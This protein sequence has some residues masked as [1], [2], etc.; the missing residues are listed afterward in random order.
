MDL[1]KENCS[2]EFLLPPLG[3]SRSLLSKHGFIAAYM[4]DKNHEPHYQEAVYLLFKPTSITKFEY[5]LD[6]EYDRIKNI[7]EIVEDYDYPGGYV[8]VVY[9]FPRKFLDDYKLFREGKYSKLS[10]EFKI[11]FPKTVEIE[12]NQGSRERSY[13]IPYM[14]FN[15]EKALREWWEEKIGMELDPNMELCRA[16]NG[17]DI[18]DIHK[19]VAKKETSK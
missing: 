13:S 16:P 8:I 12:L 7:S 4:D 2:T 15:R 18:L 6:C 19:I 17:A 11:L 3:L 1:L 5:F 10:N 9:R 14:V